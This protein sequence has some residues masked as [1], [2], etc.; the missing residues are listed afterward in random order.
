MIDK[1]KTQ[2][3]VP[4]GILILSLLIYLINFFFF[5]GNPGFFEGP[6]NPYFAMTLLVAAYFG[7]I[8]GISS[9]LLIIVLVMV[10]IS[11]ELTLP[12]F[13]K[14]LWVSRYIPIALN[15]VTVLILG[16][17]RDSRYKKNNEYSA[18]A[19]REKAEKE[20]LEKDVEELQSINTE[21]EERYLGQSKSVTALY[22]QIK[23]LHTQNLTETLNILLNTV[24]NF[25]WAQKA[26]IWR[27]DSSTNQ[28]IMTANKGWSAADLGYTVLNADE[29]IEGWCFRNN[30][31]FSKRM[32]QEYRHLKKMDNNRHF[33]TFPINFSSSPWG[34]LN[35][36]KMP[37]KKYNLY[38]ERFL[39]ILI[40]LAAPE[41]ERAVEY[42]SNLSFGE[43][44]PRTG[45]PGYKPLYSMIE[46]HISKALSSNNTFS[47]VLIEYRNFSAILEEFGEEESYSFLLK[48]FEKLND[49][50]KNKID[51]Y[52]Y[53]EVHQFALYFRDIDYD[54][55]SLFCLEALGIINNSQWSIK[56][57]SVFLDIILGYSSFG[58]QEISVDELLTV[59]EQILDMQKS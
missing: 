34:V 29:S 46:R 15:C 20:K 59:A 32:L 39:S 31:I 58:H 41:I 47:I 10:P 35:I 11:R 55:I 45:L 57:K 54:G 16:Q 14:N 9:L 38:V 7:K 8:Y 56:G 24:H 30:L 42:E 17:I 1:R 25:S 12:G 6:F 50:S 27:F 5:S 21:L 18:I 3:A 2:L 37:D 52:H 28:L 53:K 36:E 49:L 19:E 44:H 33:L 51:C 26:S 43:I 23:A 48:V 13:W 4:L 40:D 22:K